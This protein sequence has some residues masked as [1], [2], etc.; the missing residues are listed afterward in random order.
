MSR[1]LPDWPSQ[2]HAVIEHWRPLVFEWGTVD[3]VHFASSCVQAVTGYAP[4]ALHD[5]Y[6][7]EREAIRYLAMHGGLRA[8]AAAR[9]GAEIPPAMAQPGDVGIFTD[10]RGAALAVQCGGDAWLA[11]SRQG[12][13]MVQPSAIATAWRCVHG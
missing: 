1:R 12:L 11:P 7:N 4:L 6:S 9:L 2:L 3:C 8:L 10:E 13:V 5:V